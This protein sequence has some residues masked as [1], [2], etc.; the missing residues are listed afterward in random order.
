MSFSNPSGDWRGAVA[1]ESSMKHW[2]IEMVTIDVLDDD[3]LD[4]S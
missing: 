4:D 3:D 1:L 2:E